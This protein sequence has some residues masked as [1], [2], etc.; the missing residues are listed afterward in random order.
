VVVP[1]LLVPVPP[2]VEP[3]LVDGE[4]GETKLLEPLL[5]SLELL[6]ELDLVPE[7]DL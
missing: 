7:V 5:S 6:L 4:S 2:E 1:P 3:E